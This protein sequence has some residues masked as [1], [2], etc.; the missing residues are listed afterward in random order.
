MPPDSPLRASPDELIERLQVSGLRDRGGGWSLAARKW[1][2]VRVEGR[3]PVVVANGAEG[4][5][6][7]DP[8]SPGSP[9]S[10]ER[11]NVEAAVAEQLR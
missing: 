4:R 5:R 8:F 7:S 9:D 2:A 3:N 10:P 11:A 1:A 6:D